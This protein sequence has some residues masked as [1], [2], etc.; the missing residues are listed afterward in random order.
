MLRCSKKKKK[1]FVCEH[2]LNDDSSPATLGTG[3]F[4]QSI[5]YHGAVE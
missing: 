3:L 2:F 5:P 4:N 1:Y